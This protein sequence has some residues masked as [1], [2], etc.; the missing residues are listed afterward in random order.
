M[1]RN[2]FN[3]KKIDKVKKE[4]EQLRNVEKQAGS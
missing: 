1:E 3:S 2:L 4:M